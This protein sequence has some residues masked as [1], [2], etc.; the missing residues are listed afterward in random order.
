MGTLND[1]LGVRRFDSLDGRIVEALDITPFLAQSTQFEAAVRAR[2]ARF[3]DLT[4]DTLATIRRIDRDG[5]LLRVVADNVSGLRLP[6]LF[7]KAEQLG[8][9]LTGP[10]A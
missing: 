8:A 5:H 9:P 6:D 1:G 10:A 3:S 2:A 7:R 4:L